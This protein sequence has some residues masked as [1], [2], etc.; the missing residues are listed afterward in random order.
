MFVIRSNQGQTVVRF[1]DSP[2][3]GHRL[4]SEMGAYVASLT[5]S[6]SVEQEYDY[7]STTDEYV[8]TYRDTETHA[9]YE[10]RTQIELKAAR[11]VTHVA[12]M[13]NLELV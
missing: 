4:M 3:S 11:L 1:S 12:I 8:V 10:L 2:I 5:G 6:Y 7:D 9:Q 13:T